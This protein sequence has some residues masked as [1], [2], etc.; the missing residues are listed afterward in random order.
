MSRSQ[1]GQRGGKSSS[2]TTMR[3]SSCAEFGSLR[4]RSYGTQWARQLAPPPGGLDQPLTSVAR[5]CS[6]P[7]PLECFRDQPS[8]GGGG[9][10]QRVQRHD[11]REPEMHCAG[12]KAF[13]RDVWCGRIQ[14]YACAGELHCRRLRARGP[15]VRDR[16]CVIDRTS[17]G[18]DAA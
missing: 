17:P 16:A 15:E 14:R 4:S 13:V 10:R 12:W 18:A 3:G 9:Q 7:D 11:R 2:F 8:R 6:H 5:W 1:R